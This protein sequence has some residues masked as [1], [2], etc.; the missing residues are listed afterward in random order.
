MT[1]KALQIISGDGY[2]FYP[3]DEISIGDA[4]VIAV[5]LLKQKDYK[6]PELI[7]DIWGGYGEKA[8]QQ[9]VEI[10]AKNMGVE[11]YAAESALGLLI[12]GVY[13]DDPSQNST[14]TFIILDIYRYIY[15]KLYN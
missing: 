13:M 9:N 5:N 7:K 12:N 8:Y 1:A 11:P 10:Y 2:R 3:D 14:K 4:C 15:D 6:V